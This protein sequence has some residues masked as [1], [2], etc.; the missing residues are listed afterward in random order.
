[1][2]AFCYLSPTQAALY[3]RS[4]EE[5]A[6]ALDTAEGMGRRGPCSRS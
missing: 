3:Q 1:M 4:V 2:K 5:L 6:E